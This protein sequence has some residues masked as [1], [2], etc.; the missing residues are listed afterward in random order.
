MPLEGPA[1]LEPTVL[2]VSTG[3]VST[4]VTIVPSIFIA[5]D[6]AW[7]TVTLHVT[8]HNVTELLQ[9]P[10]PPAL[11]ARL[12]E[13]LAVVS[14]QPVE[15]VVLTAV[16]HA[17]ANPRNVAPGRVGGA[18]PNWWMG[19]A[20]NLTWHVSRRANQSGLECIDLANAWNA[21][22]FVVDWSACSITRAS[23]QVLEPR[24]AAPTAPALR[25][26]LSMAVAPN[27]P[28]DSEDS[29][30]DRDTDRFD[31][32]VGVSC[33]VAA[34]VVVMG[35]LFFRCVPAD[36]RRIEATEEQVDRQLR[37]E[38][39]TT[40]K[41]NVYP[42]E[43]LD[44]KEFLQRAKASRRRP[45]AQILREETYPESPPTH[46]EAEVRPPPQ[47]RPPPSAPLH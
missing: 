39:Q 13:T 8:S 12:T 1:A 31:I 20:T 43:S 27:T 35:A 24:S 5:S 22:E 21:S 26:G 18:F 36:S 3:P 30:W 17:V 42:N 46:P 44:N 33:G 37:R 14:N 10:S 34:A 16:V 11:L 6:H 19:R 7:D 41:W 15:D 32:I 9:P 23:P 29:D 38:T 28:Y 4:A 40:L 45:T 25:F 2:T 47:Y